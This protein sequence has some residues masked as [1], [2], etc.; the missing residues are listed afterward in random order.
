MDMCIKCGEQPAIETIFA[1]GRNV[2]TKSANS[3]PN[4]CTWNE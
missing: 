4:F 3:W 1:V 2:C